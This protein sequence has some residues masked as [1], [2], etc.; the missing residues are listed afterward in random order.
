LLAVAELGP[1]PRIIERINQWL[2]AKVINLLRDGG[3]N[4]YRVAQA[5]LPVLTDTSFSATDFERFEKLFDRVN[6]ILA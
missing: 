1:H 4:H 2:K 6:S 3:F 5:L